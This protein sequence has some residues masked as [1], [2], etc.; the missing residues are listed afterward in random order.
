MTPN[1]PE[2][3]SR[4]SLELGRPKPGRRIGREAICRSMSRRAGSAEPYSCLIGMPPD[5]SKSCCR[6]RGMWAAPW[7]GGRGLKRD[8]ASVSRSA[9]LRLRS[10]DTSTAKERPT[11]LGM[12][13]DD[14]LDRVRR[15]G[16]LLERGE[17]VA[18]DVDRLAEERKRRRRS[19]GPGR[20]RW[21]GGERSNHD[22]RRGL[23]GA[24]GGLLPHI[25]SRIQLIGPQA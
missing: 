6:Q 8:P 4:P 19:A 5:I 10:R 20:L 24:A 14:V 17:A 7:R 23:V 11:H 18:Q 13:L 1:W 25:L 12:S 9:P 15:A 21:R 3:C 16:R 2:I 22:E